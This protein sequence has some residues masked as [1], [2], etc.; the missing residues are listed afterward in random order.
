M[1][2][3]RRMLAQ[4]LRSLAAASIGATYTAI[5]LP[6]T[7]MIRIIHTV[8][9]TDQTIMFSFT[10]NTDHFILPTGGFLLLDL[11]TNRINDGGFFVSENTQMF[12]RH[13]GAAPATG[14]VYISS[15]YAF[16]VP[17]E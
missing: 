12:A 5:G 6:L 14:A 1:A 10:G 9:L 11:S 7:N 15:F 17:R 2:Q 3:S 16:E 8:N 4:A 13:I